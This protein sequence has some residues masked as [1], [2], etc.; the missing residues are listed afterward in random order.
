[1]Y[2][3]LFSNYQLNG[4]EYEFDYL[5]NVWRSR[6]KKTE[7]EEMR[8]RD[9]Y[10]RFA[11]TTSSVPAPPKPAAPPRKFLSN[12][13]PYNPRMNYS[14]YPLCC[15]AGV[16][17]GFNSIPVGSEPIRK[18]IASALATAKTNRHGIIS[19]V[20]TATQH[21]QNKH[22]HPALIEAGFMPVC[23]SGNPNHSNATNLIMYVKTV[24]GG[25]VGYITGT[26]YN[27][28]V[29]DAPTEEQC[30]IPL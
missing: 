10:G 21:G 23:R 22:I 13:A 7:E 24:G 26:D 28:F 29:K 15:G 8:K 3:S 2:R 4:Q 12:Y 20:V 17:S 16:W 1:M 27:D 6:I 30:S 11:T 18:E 25:K 5:A 19:C 9:V 14:S